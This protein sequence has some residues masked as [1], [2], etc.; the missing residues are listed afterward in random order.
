MGERRRNALRLGFDGSLKLEFHGSNVTSDAGLLAFSAQAANSTRERNRQVVAGTSG[1]VAAEG[2]GRPDM[3]PPWTAS[4]I[5]E[6][7]LEIPR[8][9][10]TRVRAGSS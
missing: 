9:R 7:S 8:D 5:R 2:G 1:T 10:G 6:I 4:A 3:P